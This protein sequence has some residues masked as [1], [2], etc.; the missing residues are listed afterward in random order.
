MTWKEVVAIGA[1]IIIVLLGVALILPYIWP[2]PW[3]RP[4]PL[5][6]PS[7]Q[8]KGWWQFGRQVDTAIVGQPVTLKIEIIGQAVSIG[9][10]GI[11]IRKDIILW[12]DVT[13]HT[14]SKTLT[15]VAGQNVT[16]ETTFVPDA[17]TGSLPGNVREY[18]FKLYWNGICI[19]DPATA[20]QRYG[21]HATS[22]APVT[23]SGGEFEG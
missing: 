1:V 16:V 11:E 6:A 10:L 14:D 12:F 21:L 3:G 22:G 2:L 4:P 17:P 15:L 20:G 18:F 9:T 5:G 19:Y 13:V 8:F 7:W 23:Y